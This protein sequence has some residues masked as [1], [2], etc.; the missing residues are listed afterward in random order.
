[1]LCIGSR[2]QPWVNGKERLSPASRQLKADQHQLAEYRNIRTRG[3][4]PVEVTKVVNVND[5]GRVIRWETRESSRMAGERTSHDH[6]VR[7]HARDKKMHTG[8]FYFALTFSQVFVDSLGEPWYY[9]ITN[10]SGSPPETVIE[11]AR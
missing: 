6:K 7:E 2:G 11:T 3:A 4:G 8:H 9:K 5:V 10:R 1:M